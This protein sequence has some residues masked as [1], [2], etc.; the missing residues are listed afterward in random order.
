MREK[1]RCASK[2]PSRFSSPRE[3]K[4]L[5]R[6]LGLPRHTRSAMTAVDDGAARH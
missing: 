2:N 3:D 5:S 4:T 6:V 1:W